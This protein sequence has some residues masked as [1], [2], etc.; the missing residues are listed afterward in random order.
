MHPALRWLACGLAVAVL[1]WLAFAPA[2]GRAPAADGAAADAAG[3]AGIRSRAEAGLAATANPAG[4]RVQVAEHDAASL[5]R[6]RARLA[7]SSLRGAQVDGELVFDEAGRV[8]PD[9]G[10]RRVFDHFLSLTGEFAPDEITALLLDHVRQRHGERAAQE[11]AGWFDR[12]VGLRAELAGATLADDLAVRLSQLQEARRRW[13]GAAAEALFGEEEAQIAHTLARRAVLADAALAPALREA[14]L[15]RLEA[16]R[17]AAQRLVER[18]ASAALLAEE[19]S[20][21][22]ESDGTD[23]AT[24]A[25]ERSALFGP[26][27]AQRLAALDVQR[28]AWDRRVADYLAARDRIRSDRRYDEAARRRALHQLL[29][30]RFDPH[31]RLRIEAL[32]GVGALPG[33]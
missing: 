3:P 4:A 7:R 9:A 29:S 18:E 12:Y 11:I 16:S 30:T 25:A 15:A 1:L 21:Q 5:E 33:G 13:F 2:G 8:R 26:E 20:R 23:A 19:Q 24:R 14:E 28:A 32:E 31:E 10:L 22:F 6:L 17:P 27:A